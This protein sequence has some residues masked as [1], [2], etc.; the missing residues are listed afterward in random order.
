MGLAGIKYRLAQRRAQQMVSMG[1]ARDAS[2][3]LVNPGD[4]VM[5]DGLPGGYA[6]YLRTAG[7]LLVVRSDSGRDWEVEQ[8]RVHKD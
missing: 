5:V 1:A 6:T 3:Q 8:N 2:N 7:P 4:L